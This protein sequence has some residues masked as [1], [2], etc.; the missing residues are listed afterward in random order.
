MRQVN[1]CIITVILEQEHFQSFPFWTL[2]VK[3]SADGD[4]LED[5]STRLA[6]ERQNCG[7]RS[8]SSYV[9]QWVDRTQQSA[10]DTTAVWWRWLT[11]CRQGWRSH[12]M[13]TFVYQH[14]RL[15]SNLL[16]YWQQTLRGSTFHGP[17]LRGLKKSCIFWSRNLF[18]I[19]VI[20]KSVCH[21]STVLIWLALDKIS[22]VYS[23]EPTNS[24]HAMHAMQVT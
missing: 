23:W 4:W 11:V 6:R 9:E 22:S 2:A 20:Y 3:C 5:C 24:G 21:T 7:L 12:A 16:A 18:Y 19:C 15:E 1:R 13:L 17:I 8:L 14:G 10:G